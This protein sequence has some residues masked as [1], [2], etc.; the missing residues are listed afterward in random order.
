MG[1][2]RSPASLLNELKPVF[3]KSKN[4][5]M[6]FGFDI[7]NMKKVNPNFI[8]QAYEEEGEKLDGTRKFESENT[9]TEDFV[10]SEG[11][12]TLL[13]ESVKEQTK[14]IEELSDRISK[15]G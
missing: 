9:G 15:I 5:S 14:V 4:G 3:S 6:E 13:V 12:I 11:I 1:N 2:K 8:R 7:K 10:S